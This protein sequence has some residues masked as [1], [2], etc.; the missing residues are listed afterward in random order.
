MKYSYKLL[1]ESA[2]NEYLQTLLRDNM[3]FRLKKHI[4]IMLRWQGYVTLYLLVPITCCSIT[5]SWGESS[6]P[7]LLHLQFSSE[8]FCR[9]FSCLTAYWTF[10]PHP[11]ALWLYLSVTFC[12]SVTLCK[13]LT[14]NVNKALLGVQLL[15]LTTFSAVQYEVI[16]KIGIILQHIDSQVKTIP[17]WSVK[18]KL[19]FSTS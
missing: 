18:P 15:S 9:N 3:S 1:Y 10:S 7:Q 16:V 19:Q 8:L 4:N 2:L 14:V 11:D 17:Q 6:V 12:A 5:V 13:S